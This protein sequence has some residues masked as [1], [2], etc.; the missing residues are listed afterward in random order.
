MLRH[1]LVGAGSA[2]GGIRLGNLVSLS[3]S[4][5]LTKKVAADVLWYTEAC[6]IRRI[7]R[8]TARRVRLLRKRFETEH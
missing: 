8:K 5:K 2:A 6:P 1:L 3:A 7:D 4:S